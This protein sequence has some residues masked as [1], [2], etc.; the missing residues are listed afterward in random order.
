MTAGSEQ[1]APQ[2]GVEAAQRF[3][4]AAFSDL[5]EAIGAALV[6]GGPLSD[7]VLVLSAAAPPRPNLPRSIDLAE[8]PALAEAIAAGSVTPVLEEAPLARPVARWT[9]VP[10]V[11]GEAVSGAA[12][13]GLRRRLSSPELALL[14][15]G[16]RSVGAALAALREGVGVQRRIAR[17][18][19]SRN[20]LD[21]LMRVSDEGVCVID[22]DGRVSGWS[23]GAERL[24]GWKREDVTGKVLPMVEP[25][26][27]HAQVAAMRLHAAAVGS[28]YE[29][30]F[31]V[32][33]ADGSTG[34]VRVG[35]TPLADA[36]G[37]PSGML[38]VFRSVTPDVRVEDVGAE[39][40]S[41]VTQELKNPLTAICGYAQLLTR[42]E[43]LE[44]AGKRE[45]IA[46]A[47]QSRAQQMAESVDDLLLAAAIQREGVGVRVAQADLAEV[48]TEVVARTG[49]QR[50]LHRLVLEISPSMPTVPL[51][52]ERFRQALRGL[53]GYAC[54]RSPEGG[55]VHVRASADDGAAK[56]SVTDAGARI[57][58]GLAERLFEPFALAGAGPWGE[59]EG[60][61]LGL[62]LMR[63]IV[64]AHGGHVSLASE[65]DGGTTFTVSLPAAAEAE[66]A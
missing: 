3:L 29:A 6:V 7:G 24:L 11:V 55:E 53:L 8:H 44:V 13:V 52:V 23:D 66:S 46:R 26:K 30:V 50:P 51:D 62:Y 63:T 20:V 61:G 9:V 47:L 36:D 48:V 43:L 17:L 56:V 1:Q 18:E 37:M 15:A 22:L 16:G 40:V 32:H 49:E 59:D 12:L 64:E 31:P 57:E 4:Q 14:A 27:R 33:L 35:V 60:L 42:P 54:G 19:A 28:A 45:H 25:A 39:F 5:R 21:A 38:C 41:L 58:P 2:P 65:L 34:A 10:L